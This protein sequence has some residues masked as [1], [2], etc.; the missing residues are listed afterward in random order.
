M[1]KINNGD[2]APPQPLTYLT[3]A[4]VPVRDEIIIF[5][6]RP[7]NRSEIFVAERKADF[8]RTQLYRHRRVS[9]DDKIVRGK[10]KRP[11]YYK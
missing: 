11:L 8:L 6:Q 5:T 7:V 4:A 9:V 3:A 2:T 1:V 10:Y